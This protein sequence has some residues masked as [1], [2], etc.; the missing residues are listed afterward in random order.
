MRYTDCE[1]Q[2]K[3]LVLF[4]GLFFAYYSFSAFL[5]QPGELRGITIT[6]PEY[7]KIAIP[8]K[9]SKIDIPTASETGTILAF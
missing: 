8:V 7:K 3:T 6:L 5:L 1:K 2:L 4:F 9:T